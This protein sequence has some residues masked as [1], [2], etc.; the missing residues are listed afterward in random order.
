VRRLPT[1]T[2]VAL[3]LGAA[4]IAAAILLVY[5]PQGLKLAA[6][7]SDI[8]S[9][10]IAIQA[11]A[12][13]AAIIPDMVRQIE[14]MK[15]RYRGFDRRMPKRKELAGFLH[16][17]SAILASERLTNQ[18]T[19]PGNPK[20]G[21]LYYTLPIIMKLQGPYLSLTSLLGQINKMERLTRIQELQIVKDLKK[22][23]NDLNI[24]LQMNIYFT[25]S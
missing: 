3:G 11:D 13:Q 7:R 9:K 21:K 23:T 14:T 5:I 1:D 16:E 2:W 8:A 18:N 10:R 25:E 12:E 15:K 4:I 19:E 6:I 20:K 17:I 22:K 24:E